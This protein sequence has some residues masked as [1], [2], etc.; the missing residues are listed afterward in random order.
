MELISR[1]Q[2]LYAGLKKYFLGTP[3][4]EGHVA[5]R[6]VKCC[7]CVECKKIK[8]NSYLAGW[9]QRNVEKIKQD[10]KSWSEK[11]AE[12]TKTYKAMKYQANKTEVLQKAKEYYSSNKE[13]V[14]STV[15]RYRNENRELI[16]EKGR[17][18]YQE[19]CEQRK[20]SSHAIR[21]KRAGC[22]GSYSKDDV[23][24]LLVLQ[25]RTCACCRNKLTKY[26]IDHINPL[27]KGGTN[28]PENL[29]LLCQ[30]CNQRKSDKHPIDFMQ[31]NGFLL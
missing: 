8:T 6:W 18:Y 26:H 5:Q 12:Y 17:I 4:K 23:S 27:A 7:A 15:E 10:M 13:K 24:K 1:K 19:N 14:I 16:N 3:C 30:N 21:T 20:A 2:A 31:Q 29:Q 22:E 28:W 25:R 11:N 9:R